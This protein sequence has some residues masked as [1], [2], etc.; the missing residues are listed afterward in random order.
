MPHG[1]AEDVRRH[2]KLVAWVGAKCGLLALE[3]FPSLL[4][5][6]T[7][8]LVLRSVGRL[9]R[10]TAISN[11]LAAAAK[12]QPRCFRT[13]GATMVR[14]TERDMTL[15]DNEGLGRESLGL[16]RSLAIAK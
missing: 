5:G 16:L 9:V 12:Q 15:H 1:I 14:E 4:N 6:D 2:G 7:S 8:R 10:G 11:D 13:N 3:S